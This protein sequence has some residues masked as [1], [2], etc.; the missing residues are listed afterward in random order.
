[1]TTHPSLGVKD[2]VT[3]IEYSEPSF[4][5]AEAQGKQLALI[6][7]NSVEKPSEEISEAAISI[8]V[9][10]LRMPISNK[11]FRL[12]TATGV[13]NRGT[14]GWMKMRTEVSAFNIG[15][16]SFATIPGEAYPELLNGPV[17]S[18]EG[19]DFAIAPVEVPVVRE[20]MHGKYKFVFCLANDEIGYILPKSQWD[21]NEPFT[22]G[23]KDSPYG[24]ENSLGPETASLLHKTLAEIL[25]D[26]LSN[27]PKF[28]E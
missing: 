19:N 16:L 15:P 4:E 10:S 20:M 9:K 22:Y 13:L 18:P 12:A 6:V 7:L 3:G 28:S 14:A 11:M 17:E 21:E 5:K 27:S 1:M 26:A 8:I 23:R 24:E 2:P 25:D